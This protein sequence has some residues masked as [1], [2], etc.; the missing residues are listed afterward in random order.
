MEWQNMKA[1][2]F[3]ATGNL[4]SCLRAWS[5]WSHLGVNRKLICNFL[6]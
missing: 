6:L 1:K 2:V 3:Q 4:S 5:G